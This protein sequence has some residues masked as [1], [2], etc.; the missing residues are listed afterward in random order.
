MSASR[1]WLCFLRERTFKL[2]MLNTLLVS[3]HLSAELKAPSS[4]LEL[5]SLASFNLLFSGM[6][7]LIAGSS[8]ATVFCAR[9]EV[10]LASYTGVSCSLRF[11]TLCCIVVGFLV[12]GG[13]RQGV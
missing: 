11:F 4:S 13:G 7:F 9:D 2:R 6:I 5:L 10:S 3:I 12:K 1:S 8:A